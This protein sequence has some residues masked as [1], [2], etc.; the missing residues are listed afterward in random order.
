[1]RKSLSFEEFNS[2]LGALRTMCRLGLFDAKDY[3]VMWE[4][5][6]VRTLNKL[7]DFEI[8]GEDTV[9]GTIMFWDK[10]G[11][12]INETRFKVTK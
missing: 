2:L 7:S 6:P 11:Q 4:R 12:F 10:D 8:D 1:M 9:G 3:C 5:R